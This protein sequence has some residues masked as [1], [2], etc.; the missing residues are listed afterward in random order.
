[1][2][3][4]E[5]ALSRL[6]ANVGEAQK[7]ADAL[8][9]SL[10]RTQ[11]AVRQGN[12]SGI[13]KGLGELRALG[14]EAAAA[15]AELAGQW[16]FNTAAHMQSGYL[17]ELREA[18]TAE[19][20]TLFERDG[21]IYAFPL[22][23]R[24]LP[25]EKAVRLGRKVERAIRPGQVVGRLK[26]LQGRVQKLNEQRFLDLLYRA[27]QRLA[28]TEWRRVERGAGPI[29][30]LSDI[31]EV[32]TLLPRSDYPAEEFGRDLLLLDRQ[33][34]LTARDG[35]GFSFVGST[36]GKSAKKIVIYDEHG[37]TRE[38]IAIAFIKES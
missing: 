20:V 38:F 29:V 28:G 13:E 25:G 3:D 1:M 18:A 26:A 19:G 6:E 2:R 15:A 4:F 9:K 30:L 12:V 5:D 7:C 14:E 33:P 23:I 11:T 37:N 16:Q 32:I 8:L 35:S 17:E 24:L 27:Y 31:H 10:R 21:R 34:Q 22:L 36:L